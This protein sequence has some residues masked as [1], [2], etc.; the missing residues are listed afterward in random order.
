MKAW[1]YLF[2]VYSNG[3]EGKVQPSEFR[4]ARPRMGRY[5]ELN[6][7]QH[8]DGPIRRWLEWDMIPLVIH[9]E[10]HVLIPQEE[11][12]CPKDDLLYGT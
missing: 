5:A 1:T 2:S 11:C 8:R 9:F 6:E 12:I 3:D 4:S 10:F 7:K